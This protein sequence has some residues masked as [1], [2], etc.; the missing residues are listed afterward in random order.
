[1]MTCYDILHSLTNNPVDFKI[2]LSVDAISLMNCMNGYL[3]Q[4]VLKH[5]ISQ[6]FLILNART[7]SM[8]QSKLEY[9]PPSP[10]PLIDD[11]GYS[12]FGL[13]YGWRHV[14]MYAS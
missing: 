2:V 11:F 9:P 7:Q 10:F 5:F 3:E 13:G 1:M 8:K 6:I 14:I 12:M 4:H